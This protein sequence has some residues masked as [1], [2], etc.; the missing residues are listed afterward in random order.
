M[1]G[2]PEKILPHN[3]C[4]LRCIVTNTRSRN[5]FG[6]LIRLTIKGE[7]LRATAHHPVWIVRGEELNRWP[8]REHCPA[9]PEGASVT[10]RRVDAAH[11]NA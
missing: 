5:Y 4:Y 2:S 8:A 6:K 11:L 9:L 1:R 10:S 7:T 3:E